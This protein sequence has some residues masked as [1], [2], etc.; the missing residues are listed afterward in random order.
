MTAF[1]SV[2][3]PLVS[4]TRKAVSLRYYQSDVRAG[5]EAEWAAGHANVLAVMPTGAGKTVLFTSILS[6]HQ[7]AACAIA[8]RQELV[9]QISLTLNSFGVRH[10][11]V[12]PDKVVKLIIQRHL[13]EHKVTHY[14]PSAMIGVGGVDTVVL[15]DGGKR[16]AQHDTWRRS[17]TLWV[18][19]ECFPAGTLID[20][21]PIEQVKVGDYVTAFNEVT[22]GFEK[23]EVVRLF[24][25]P[26]P[27][28][29][30]MFRSGHHV[31]RCTKGH[32]IFTRRGWVDAQY[33]T[34]EDEILVD[35]MYALQQPDNRN[36]RGATLPAPQNG[37]DFLPQEMR[38]GVSRDESPA[39]GVSTNA[40]RELL[41]MPGIDRD[42][43][44]S[45]DTLDAS[46][47]S[48]LQQSMQRRLPEP[49]VFGDDESDES[50]PRVSTH[51]GPQPHAT[52]G[53][54]GESLADLEAVEAP[55]I[56]PRR[57]RSTCYGSGD[58]TV[59]PIGGTQLS[60]STEYQNR[61][62]CWP[63]GVPAGLQAGLGELGAKI[64]NR[65]GREQPH[66]RR[67]ESA[68]PQEGALFKWL[69]LD[70]FEI[71]QCSDSESAGRSDGD[72]FVYNF[73]V[74]G[75]H[76]Y[77]ANGVVVHN[78][79]HV[80]KANKWGRA[81][82]M[83]PNAQRGL[84]V[85]ATPERPDGQGLG[86]H[87]DGLFDALVVGPGMRELIDDGYLC[88]YKIWTVPFEVDYDH[89]PV[90]AS[91]ELVQAKLVA[92]EGA[93]DRLVGKIVDTYKKRAAGLRGIC[94][95]SSVKKAEEVAEEFRQAGVP[96]LAVDGKSSDELR[97][98]A[99]R[100]LET[101]EVLMLV[102]CD[103]VGEG[104]DVPAV[105]VVIMATRTASFVRFSQWFG[106]MLRL[107]LTDA[108]KA[109]YDALDSAGRR[110]RIAASAKPFGRLIDHGGNIVTH[111][112]PPDMRIA[113]WT[114]D[115]RERRG[116]AP[117]EALPYRV[118]TNPG[119][120]LLAG[121]W[122]EYRA[123][124]L[125]DDDLIE[126]RLAVES[127]LP[128]AQPYSA[129]HRDCPFCGYQRF[130][131]AR[132]TP[133]E[134]D[135]D[136]QL[137]DADA[138]AALAAA[139]PGTVEDYRQYLYDTGLTG[140][141][142]EANV[143]RHRERLAALGKLGEAMGKWGGVWHSRGET[144]SQIQRRFYHTFGLDVMSAQALKRADADKLADRVLDATV[145]GA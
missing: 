123:A 44:C 76:T 118:C 136:L 5:I 100:H 4:A 93:D 114:L 117:S 97:E 17:V 128:C 77:V 129:I 59:R 127:E 18:Q 19:D 74:E 79:H 42:F 41:G 91:G 15:L 49:S 89:V 144:D 6:D 75:L 104:V 142:V 108:L 86:R 96:A 109:G 26:A 68:G 11:L 61:P 139:R 21:K 14:D 46:Q 116:S 92:A 57:K 90:G 132:G 103:L 81:A 54:P 51:E 102:N 130:I 39:P 119:I 143:K 37:S 112:G 10:R 32:P 33:L 64:S 9:A 145:S 2:V 84:G 122:G 121:E 120:R 73:E 47:Q 137:L 55:A 125:R 83:F 67:E 34:T 82:E 65:S 30:V 58:G 141:K 16:K 95:V 40:N 88:D 66:L 69:G 133:E 126:Q 94:F 107:A 45:F 7:G 13:R 50:A 62:S 72:G 135:G 80:L 124:G 27:S 56:D 25:N 105:E 87:A 115:R 8:H 1:P 98:L 111:R 70:S 101:G 85:T 63:V 52:R 138:L 23:R 140:I 134:V 35:E 113:P 36:Y 38:D 78:C 110:A 131:A 24:K 106:R 12:A 3:T 43:G 60:S 28:E 20:G 29:M 53:V 99:M 22:G 31:V 71:Y 48:L